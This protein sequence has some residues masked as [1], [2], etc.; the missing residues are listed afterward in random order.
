MKPFDAEAEEAD[1]PV[2]LFRVWMAAAV[3]TELNDPDAVALATATGDGVP[4]VRM[5]LMKRLDERGFSFYTK[6]ESQKGRELLE[7]PNAAMCF[8]WKT[9][10]RQVRVEGV[11]RELPGEDA[12]GG[13]VGGQR[14]RRDQAGRRGR[15]RERHR[16]CQR[17]RCVGGGR[18]PDD[19]AA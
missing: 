17:H 3:E 15:H 6:A 18:V 1:D 4:S 16:Q 2:A 11:V 9:Q 5:V 14:R 13:G 7:N 19:A 10:R 12:V 8:H